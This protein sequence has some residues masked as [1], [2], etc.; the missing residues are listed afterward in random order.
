MSNS[1][2]VG[3]LVNIA[4]TPGFLNDEAVLVDPTTVTLT[5]WQQGAA[6]TTTVTYTYGDGSEIVKASTGLYSANV[7]STDFAPG[8]W[9]YQWQGT[10]AAQAV[11]R[12]WFY[13][14]S[15]TPA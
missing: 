2:L 3:D 6:S 5:I 11:A 8:I 1:Y 14:G 12:N 13:L 10:G 9:W 15:D 4:N 7:D